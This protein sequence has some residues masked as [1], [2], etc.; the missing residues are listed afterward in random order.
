MLQKLNEHFACD[1]KNIRYLKTKDKLGKNGLEYSIVCGI[2]D[3]KY[4]IVVAYCKKYD[5][6]IVE[7]DKY[8]EK[9]NL[10]NNLEKL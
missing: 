3:I 7:L 6:R 5:D 8:L 2:K 9:I 4:E 10:L 1:F